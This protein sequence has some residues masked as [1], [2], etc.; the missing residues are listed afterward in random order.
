MPAGAG[1][2]SLEVG[3]SM[4]AVVQSLDWGVHEHEATNFLASTW[5]AVNVLKD[6]TPVHKT[7]RCRAK[8]GPAGVDVGVARDRWMTSS[9]LLYAL[10]LGATGRTRK[11]GRV[12]QNTWSACVSRSSPCP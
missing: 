1:A 11:P 6:S 4:V 9:A 12:E 10:A 3:I 2:R 5:D 7:P 8:S